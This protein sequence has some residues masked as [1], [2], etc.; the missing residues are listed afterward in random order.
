MKKMI[1]VVFL[2]V[3]F[4]FSIHAQQQRVDI[5]VKEIKV[6]LVQAPKYGVTVHKQLPQPDS[7]LKWL[8][9]EADLDSSLEWADDVVLRFYVV[10]QYGN[11]ARG[12]HVPQDRWDVLASSVTVTSLKKGKGVVPM[13]IDSTTVKKYGAVAVQQFIPEV[14]VQVMYKGAV[15]HTKWMRNEQQS[16][17]F[18]EKKQPKSGFLVDITK[19]P[20]WPAFS[21]NY[22][23]VKPMTAAP[24]F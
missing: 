12:D 13:Y 6:D 21:E 5:V 11:N 10:A 1:I 18:W 14:V 24:A 8:I 3:S 15:Q 23:Q 7:S 20:W 2:A 17:R 19:S 9:I 4:A 16:G 22:E